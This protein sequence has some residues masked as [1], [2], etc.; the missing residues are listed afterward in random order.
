MKF[1]IQ[2]AC[3][4]LAILSRM[5]GMRESFGFAETQRTTCESGSR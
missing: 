2:R 5:A 1:D 3:D 4:W